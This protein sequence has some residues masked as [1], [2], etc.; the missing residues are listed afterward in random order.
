MDAISGTV[1]LTS[2]V[3]SY[4]T[5]DTANSRMKFT[6]KRGQDSG[7]SGW[8]DTGLS[9]SSSNWAIKFKLNVP[10]RS[11]SGNNMGYF[12]FSSTTTNQ[13]S[14]YSSPSGNFIGYSF[15]ARSSG[16]TAA[17]GKH[18]LMVGNTYGYNLFNY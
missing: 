5:A 11:V 6:I 8:I 2:E 12:G 1:G 15:N 3:A 7:H 10:T 14:D 17:H 16:E 13:D 9:S 18:Q 4:I